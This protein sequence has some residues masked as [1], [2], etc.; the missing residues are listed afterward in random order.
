MVES[1]T[2][3]NKN[4]VS[5]DTTYIYSEHCNESSWIIAFRSMRKQRTWV[6][7]NIGR[8]IG[9]T[10]SSFYNAI[11]FSD[12]HTSVEQKMWNY[13]QT[14]RKLRLIRIMTCWKY[15]DTDGSKQNWILRSDKI[16]KWAFP[17]KEYWTVWTIWLKCMRFKDNN[18][19]G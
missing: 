13:P 5:V 11:W 7:Q 14:G 12:P 9:I 19:D 15:W 4:A 3:L 2:I 17:L 18:L 1:H 16:V 8:V 10:E 6:T